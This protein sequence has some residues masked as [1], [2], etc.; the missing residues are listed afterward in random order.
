[1]DVSR[2]LRKATINDTK[3]QNEEKDNTDDNAV[4]K[5]RHATGSCTEA[6]NM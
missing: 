4:Q 1:M 6:Y 5:R 3:T 2:V